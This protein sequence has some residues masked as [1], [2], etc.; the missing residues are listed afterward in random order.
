MT[1]DDLP[2][3][4]ASTRIANLWFATGHGM[5]GMSMSN[6]TAELLAAQMLGQ[7]S[8]IDPRPYL[9]ARFAL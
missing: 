1:P 7:D 3:I 6:A 5:L 9:P 8:V 4:G 2:I